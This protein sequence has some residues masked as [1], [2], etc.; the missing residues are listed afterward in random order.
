MRYRLL[1]SIFAQKRVAKASMSIRVVGLYLESLLE[2]RDCFVDPP[3]CKKNVSAVV[4]GFCIVGLQLYRLFEV[5]H[6]FIGLPFS[7]Q[8]VA[9]IHFYK[10]GT[11]VVMRI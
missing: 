9:D 11:E 10:R 5:G 7:R 3:L 1:Q 4:I 8:G 6:G 2:V